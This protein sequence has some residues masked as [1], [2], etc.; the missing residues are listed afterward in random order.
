MLRRSRWSASFKKHILPRC[1]LRSRNWWTIFGGDL[2]FEEFLNHWI[3]CNWLWRFVKIRIDCNFLLSFR[4]LLYCKTGG[5]VPFWTRPQRIAY[6]FQFHTRSL[7][8]SRC[9]DGI[10]WINHVDVVGT[11]SNLGTQLRDRRYTGH[12]TCYPKRK[13][14]MFFV[15]FLEQS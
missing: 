2:A 9:F 7:F 3:D 14:V 1:E 11:C 4:S 10:H 8:N 13:I 12:N 5:Y 6:S 15:Y